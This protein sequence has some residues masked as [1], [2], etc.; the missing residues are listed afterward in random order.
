MAPDTPVEVHTLFD[1]SQELA[2]R[3][4]VLYGQMVAWVFTLSMLSSP[5]LESIDLHGEAQWFARSRLAEL[6]ATFPYCR[7]PLPLCNSRSNRA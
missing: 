6:A 1:G 3:E 7:D 5:R 4:K 2:Q